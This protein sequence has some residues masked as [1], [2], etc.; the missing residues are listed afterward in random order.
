[1]LDAI[2]EA[3]RLLGSHGKDL[4]HKGSLLLALDFLQAHHSLL[5]PFFGN[6][7]VLGFLLTHLP[8][9]LPP[10]LGV[11]GVQ[12]F[13]LGVGDIALDQFLP[14]RSGAFGDVWTGDFDFAELGWVVDAAQDGLDGVVGQVGDVGYAGDVPDGGV[15]GHGG[16]GWGGHVG[17]VLM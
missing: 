16:E 14:E 5:Q 6:T 3:R 2:E 11:F 8:V 1:M 17:R 7:L 15:L 10:V 4:G 13:A 12:H 9:N